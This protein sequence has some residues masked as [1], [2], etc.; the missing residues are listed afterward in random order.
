MKK[1][2]ILFLTTCTL[3]ASAQKL[4]HVINLEP[5]N[6][7]ANVLPVKI[8]HGLSY[9]LNKGAHGFQVNA[10]GVLIPSLDPSMNNISDKN[11]KN[12]LTTSAV[13]RWNALDVRAEKV[14]NRLTVYGG[15]EYT[16]HN[17][18]LNTDYWYTDRL[19][20][21]TY[22]ILQSRNTHSAKVGVEGSIRNFKLN[23][24]NGTSPINM[25]TWKAEYMYSFAYELTGINSYSISQNGNTEAI[26][27][28]KQYD[29]NPH[30]FR[31]SFQYKHFVHPKIGVYGEVE[32]MYFSNIKYSPNEDIFVYRGGEH[33]IPL[34]T[35]LK[36][37][38][39]FHL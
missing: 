1:L 34:Y 21:N 20:D 2:A 35:S 15:Y 3:N 27:L 13:Y 32:G 7:T 4:E 33:Y 9:Q 19:T 10:L 18:R 31:T 6:L 17:N 25:F 26:N 11:L 24:E 14:H 36:F 22:N 8:T 28:D 23:S 29:F 37:G 5:L 12:F 16:Q 38:I 39:S 30:G